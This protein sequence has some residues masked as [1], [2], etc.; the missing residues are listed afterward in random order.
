MDLRS[1]EEVMCRLREKVVKEVLHASIR[2][3]VVRHLGERFG[4]LDHVPEASAKLRGLGIEKVEK[5]FAI[6]HRIVHEGALPV[7][8]LAALDDVQFGFVWL[9]VILSVSAV[10]KFGVKVDQSELLRFVSG[11]YT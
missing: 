7:E 1:Y 2:D 10:K 4:L 11:L 9:L 3:A 8:D 6:R 5:T